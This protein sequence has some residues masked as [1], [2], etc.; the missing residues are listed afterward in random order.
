[1]VAI[2]LGGSADEGVDRLRAYS[3]A[4]GRP[5]ASVAAD[6]IARRLTLHD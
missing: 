1:M 2:Q 5:I 3:Y 6:I 4:C